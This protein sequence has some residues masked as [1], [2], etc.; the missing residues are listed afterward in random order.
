MIGAN[1]QNAE[2]AEVNLQKSVLIGTNLYQVNLQ[3]DNLQRAK[4]TDNNTTPEF[5]Q[6]YFL[7]HSCPTIFLSHFNPQVAGMI[8]LSY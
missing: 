1:L 2:L 5:C 7:S 8:L 3:I 4:Y 6:K